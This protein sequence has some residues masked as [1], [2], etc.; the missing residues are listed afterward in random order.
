MAEKVRC[1]IICG[2]PETNTEFIRK[3]VN[4]DDYVMCADSGYN[5][6]VKAGVTPDLC[7]GDFDSLRGEIKS[8]IE[9]VTLNTRKDD[10]DTM[11]CASLAVEKGFKEVVL[12]GADGGRLDHTLANFYVLEYLFNNKA[13]AY[14]ENEKEQ[15]QFLGAGEYTYSK[16][17]GKTFSVFPF[18]CTSCRVTYEGGCEY[19]ASGL[20]L[21]SSEGRGLSNVFSD[22]EVKIIVHSGNALIFVNKVSISNNFD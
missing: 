6:A 20:V 4:P 17:K 14:L 5:N 3:F 7:V 2:S 21:V 8:G 16:V 19:P 22:D 10:S 15:V 9:T 18:S 1:V 12:L 13:R 11:H